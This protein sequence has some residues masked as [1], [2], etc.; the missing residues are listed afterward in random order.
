MTAKMS[1]MLNVNG[2]GYG[3][4]AVAHKQKL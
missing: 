3:G 4:K 2:H 1:A